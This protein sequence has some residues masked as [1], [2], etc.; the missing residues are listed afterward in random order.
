M[1]DIISIFILLG[2]VLWCVGSVFIIDQRVP[3]YSYGNSC[4]QGDDRTSNDYL[5]HIIIFILTFP[6]DKV[7]AM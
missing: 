4:S 7:E 1:D 5:E 2:K 3:A 6:A